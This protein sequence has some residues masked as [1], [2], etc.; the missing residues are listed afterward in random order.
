MYIYIYTFTGS[1]IQSGVEAFAE[2]KGVTSFIDGELKGFE[3]NPL[4]ADT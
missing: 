2:G 1:F 4:T 3:L